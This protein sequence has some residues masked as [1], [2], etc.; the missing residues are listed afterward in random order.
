MNQS[1]NASDSSVVCRGVGPKPGNS[2][3]ADAFSGK[4][5]LSKSRKKS[6]Y[7]RSHDCNPCYVTERNNQL[8][9]S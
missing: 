9:R 1:L 6:N 5:R 7:T 2:T 4:P 8:R 3:R